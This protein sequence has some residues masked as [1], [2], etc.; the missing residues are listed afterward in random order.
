MIDNKIPSQ[1]M[2]AA[3]V[4]HVVAELSRRGMIALPTIRNLAGYDIIVASCDGKH[5]ANIQVKASQKTTH[6]FPMP[7]PEKIKVGR[8]DYYVLLRLS[9]SKS[10]YEIFMLNGREAKTAV[11]EICNKQDLAKRGRF[12]AICVDGTHKKQAPTWSKR[13]ATWTLSH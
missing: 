7:V 13:W 6:A 8:H 10:G 5:H 12:P 2:G 4:H 9:R 11:Q 3:G 1:L